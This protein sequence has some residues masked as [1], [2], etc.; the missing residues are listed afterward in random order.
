MLKVMEKF[1]CIMGDA[2]Q[3]LHSSGYLHEI[4][5]LRKYVRVSDIYI[6]LN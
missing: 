6:A 3:P 2:H 5:F 1:A 4:D